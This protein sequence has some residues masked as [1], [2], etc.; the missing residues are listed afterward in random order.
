MSAS[1]IIFYILA[2]LVV[3]FGALTVFSRK[4]FR[5]AIS[6]L[7]SL[8]FIAGIYFLWNVDFIGA[9]QIIIYVGGIVVLIIFSIFL[10][11]HSG[12]SLPKVKIGKKLLSGIMA[13]AGLGFTT[14]VVSQYVFKPV[15][16]VVPVDPSVHNIGIQMLNY[17][18][19]GY[20]F[21]FEVINILLLAALVGAIVI[22]IK[23]S[24]ET[25]K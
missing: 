24:S 21:P 4:I 7:L 12:Q 9:L 16:G 1:T 20:V 22:A 8:T 15:A 6:L 3:V 23:K 5:A 17:S 14:W 2:T 19:Y 13:I 11:H 10:T 25:G 18:D